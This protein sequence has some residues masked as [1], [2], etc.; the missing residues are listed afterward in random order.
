MIDDKN[1]PN[2]A[3]LSAHAAVA[4]GVIAVIGHLNTDASIAAAKI[5]NDAG[6]PQLTPTAAGRKLTQLGYANMFQMLG[7]TGYTGQYLADIACHVLH[8]QRIM[9][10]ENNAI[11]D[12]ELGKNF[13]DALH[14]G[15]QR[16]VETD[17]INIK[18]S[19]FN[20]TIAK[21]IASHPDLIFF[22][23]IT[24]QSGAFAKHLQEVGVGTQLLLAGGAVNAQFPKHTDEYPD[25]TLL[26]AAGN[27]IEK[28]PDFKHLEKSYGDAFSSALLPHSWRTYDAL[29]MLVEAMK[30]TNSLDPHRLSPALHQMK[31]KG[32][33]GTL[34][35]ATDGSLRNPTYTLYRAEQGH[36]K[37]I[38]PLP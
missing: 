36:W 29:A 25:H 24:P 18:K 3:I 27:P 30:L 20:S 4:A 16:V 17:S 13:T 14:N 11:F 22:T 34:S 12:Q 8:A 23:G 37:M 15:G 7:H 2:L 19:D 32:L 5:Y 28:A 10:I 21:I 31:F 26:L 38:R 9:L 35:F 6:I 1:D 33:S